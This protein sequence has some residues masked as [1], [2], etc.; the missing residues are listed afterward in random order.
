MTSQRAGPAAAMVAKDYP[1]YLTVKRANC[2]LEVPPASSPAKDAEVGPPPGPLW[3]SL[4]LSTP[5]LCHCFPSLTLC[6]PLS[7]SL[8]IS[9]TLC[10]P[11]F[12][13][14]SCL[15]LIASLPP[16]LYGSKERHLL[17][18]HLFA[19]TSL[20]HPA[21]LTDCRSTPQRDFLIVHQWAQSSGKSYPLKAQVSSCRRFGGGQGNI[22]EDP[23]GPLTCQAWT[24]SCLAA[25]TGHGT[26]ACPCGQWESFSWGS[27]S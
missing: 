11:V 20:L 6:V 18:P 22:L 24:C 23:L 27:G 1:F 26:S 8:S 15:Y 17:C 16:P 21:E 7:L 10:F 25:K 3:A 12:I 19:P 5:S 13:S 14:N 2:S 4:T 9:H